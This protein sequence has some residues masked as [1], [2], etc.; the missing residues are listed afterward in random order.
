MK[1]I[2][3]ISFM[4]ALFLSS[5][6]TLE[7]DA[8]WLACP[9]ETDWKLANRA[10]VI[11]QYEILEFVRQGDDIKNWKELYSIH[12]YASSSWGGPSPEDTLNCFKA[13]REKECPGATE[14]NVIS[15]DDSSI[16][17]EWHAKPCLG[18]PDQHEIARIL[19]GNHSRFLIRYTVKV[20]EMP[21][22]TRE[23][24]IRDLS[25]SQIEKK[26]PQ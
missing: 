8:E 17:Y 16:L 21:H 23:K 6:A 4:L 18:W 1:S 20:Y 22:E 11:G 13:N 10:A 2:V 9:F 25:T 7:T 14:W 24:W 26:K 5:C 12:N 3:S 15:K 19:Y